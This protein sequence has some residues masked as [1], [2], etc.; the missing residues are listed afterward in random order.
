[1]ALADGDEQLELLRELGQRYRKL[2]VHWAAAR[3]ALR[4]LALRPDDTRALEELASIYAETDEGERLRGVLEALYEGARDEAER[5]ERLLALALCALHYEDDLEQAVALVTRVVTPVREGR[6]LREV[7]LSTLQRALGLLRGKAPRSAYTVMVE[8]ARS[9]SPARSRALLEEALLLAEHELLDPGA[10]FETA[11]EGTAAHP[12]HEPFTAALAR[13]A[14][15]LSRIEIWVDSLE[16]AADRTASAERQAELLVRAGELCEHELS[17]GARACVLLDRAYRAV[18]SHPIEELALAAARRLYAQDLRAG[19]LAYDRLRDT[20]H[21]RAKF[22]A[23]V[24]RA[25]ALITLSRLADEVYLSRDDANRYVDAARSALASADDAQPEQRELL[26]TRLDERVTQMAQLSESAKPVSRAPAPSRKGF[27]DVE[28]LSLHGLQSAG[29]T[30]RPGGFSISP[31]VRPGGRSL[32]PSFEPRLPLAS[33]SPIDIRGQAVAVAGAS[34]AAAAEPATE[35]SSSGELASSAHVSAIDSLDTLLGAVASGQSAALDPL[36]RQLQTDPQG[37]AGLCATLLA[38]IRGRMLSVVALR[39]LRIASA[40]ASE[41]ALWRTCSQA[42]AFVEPQLRPPTGARRRDAQGAR[43]EAALAAARE[44]E[45]EQAFA[46]LAML[47]EAAA[48]LFRRSIASLIR[49]KE[50]PEPLREAPYAQLLSELG[51]I[52]GSRL[53]AYLAP[54]SEDRVS[55][56]S[57]Q[58][59]LIVIGDRTA[60]DAAGLRFR[61]ARAFECARPEHALL[62]T[63]TREDGEALLRAL[64]AAFGPAAAQGGPKISREGAALVAELWR[65]MPSAAQRNLT[66]MLSELERPLSFAEMVTELRLRSARVALFATRELDVALAQ[67][68]RD[69]DA[70]SGSAPLEP[71]SEGDFNRALRDDVLVRELL[72]YALGDAYLGSLQDP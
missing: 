32:V 22:G 24:E 59:P 30:H 17:D 4:L 65:T 37:A 56:W 3:A 31:T 29:P 43:A 72:G 21:V 69:I 14:P 11:L 64:P 61:L 57:V 39:G 23:Q 19:K 28:G 70:G 38:Q 71:R 48:P 34:S 27:S 50:A 25:H 35:T 18:P 5:H 54:S 13:F 53:D 47:V 45:E 16:A 44:S 41:H 51:Q 9:S 67:L 2:A 62:A 42:L 15:T 20:L 10:A 26:L 7:A 46:L 66:R 63:L 60:R 6:E 8:L 40:A 36:A 33:L 12:D 52:F 55:L 58:P 68:G 49:S 1:V